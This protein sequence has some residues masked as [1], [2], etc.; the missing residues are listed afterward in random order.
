M[1]ESSAPTANP[2]LSQPNFS[3]QNACANCKYWQDQR[4]HRYPPISIETDTGETY[5]FP[6]MQP[7]DWCGEHAFQTKVHDQFVIKQT[8]NLP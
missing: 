7:G 3:T 8:Y 5:K 2:T 1:I 6:I 4:C